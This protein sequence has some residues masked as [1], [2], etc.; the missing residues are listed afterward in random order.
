MGVFAYDSYGNPIQPQ[1]LPASEP[2]GKVTMFLP[3]RLT[4][5][6]LLMLGWPMKKCPWCLTPMQGRFM[7]TDIHRSEVDALDVSRYAYS[8]AAMLCRYIKSTI[9]RGQP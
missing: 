9:I 6:E 5:A 1:P 7:E 4:D 2:D 8:S 3:E